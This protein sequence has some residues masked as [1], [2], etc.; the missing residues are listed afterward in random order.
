MDVSDGE[1][2]ILSLLVE[3]DLGA[4][5]P[6][7]DLQRE[8]ARFWVFQ[9]D[10]AVA[11]R[12][13]AARGLLHLT[14]EETLTLAPQ[15]VDSALALA[16][17]RRD[18]YF[19]YYR[20]YYPRALV[21]P[22]HS[23]FCRRAFGADLS[24]EG[25]TDM[26]TLARLLDG[27]DLRPGQRVADLGCGSGLISRHIARDRGVHVTGIDQS[28]PGIACA[29][30]DCAEDDSLTFR[31][32]DLNDLGALDL[33]G[34][35]NAVVAIDSVYWVADMQATL[36]AM[37]RLLRPGGRLGI[38][39][40]HKHETTP[41]RPTDPYETRVGQAACALGLKL[42]IVD[43]TEATL[44]YWTRAQAAIA[45]LTPQF[46][47]DG[48]GLIATRLRREAEESFL[49]LFAEGRVARFLAFARP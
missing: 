17:E 38:T 5:V 7:A 30:A 42:D 14:P 8:G 11:A 40:T 23:E 33:D 41:T 4:A 49:P 1:A 6:L 29:T 43:V 35:F 19:Y 44:G 22:A 47:T 34:Q 2:Q 28:A 26:A 3:H 13:L 10:F 39:I 21:S 37:C 31:Q 36:A 48:I 20:D 24:Q 9:G 12:S 46:E 32:G 16:R 25:M 18:F 45:D 27:L 15:A